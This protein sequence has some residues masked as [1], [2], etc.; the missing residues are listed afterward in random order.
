MGRV[1]GRHCRYYGR[2][3]PLRSVT[4]APESSATDLWGTPVSA[5]QNN[6][7][8]ANGKIKGNLT[9]LTSGQLVT[10]WGEGYF[11]CVN[12]TNWDNS[13]DSIK[14]GV[15]PTAGVG[16]I[17]AYDDLAS[18]NGVFKVTDKNRQDLMIIQST[19]AGKNITQTWDLSELTLV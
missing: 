16:M 3:K 14:V 11:L 13:I 8:I 10:D 5:I 2:R 6:I 18:H 19:E 1:P 4:L 17:E 15:V 12:W 7:S 9:K